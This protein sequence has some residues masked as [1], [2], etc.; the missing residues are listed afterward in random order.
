[1]KCPFCSFE[2]NK[3][4]DSRLSKDG[5]E[6]RRRRQCLKCNRRFTTREVVVLS[7][8]AVVKKN[9]DREPFDSEKIR[10]GIKKACEKRPISMEQI[11]E[12]VKKIEQV[13][14]EF[15][16]SEIPSAKIG[17]MV[18]EELKNLDHVAY[19]RFASVYKEFKDPTQF[20]EALKQLNSTK[21]KK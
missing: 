21:N 4:L 2:E 19:V 20:M 8:P 10:T 11:N 7:F 18:M 17:E 9:G 3:V 12:I 13:C 1:V 14:I 16:E 6:I 5:T 15:G